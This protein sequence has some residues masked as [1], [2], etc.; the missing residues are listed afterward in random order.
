MIPATATAT[1]SA[2]RATRPPAAVT[3]PAGDLAEPVGVLAAEHGIGRRRSRQIRYQ[4]TPVQEH[5]SKQAKDSK[6]PG[7]SG[8][9]EDGERPAMGAAAGT[10]PSGIGNPKAADRGKKRPLKLKNVIKPWS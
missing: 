4:R 9:I 8:P 2:A 6:L 3:R 1:G 7:T 5:Q 10:N